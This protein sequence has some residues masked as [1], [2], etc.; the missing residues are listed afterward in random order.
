MLP[1]WLIIVTTAYGGN[2]QAVTA[3]RQP[4]LKTC[5]TTLAGVTHTPIEPT[6]RMRMK[7]CT[8]KKPDFW[9]D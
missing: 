1:A 3:I 4:D 2:A 8:E 6:G 7:F 9:E 5:E